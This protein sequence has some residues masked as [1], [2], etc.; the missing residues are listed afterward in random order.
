MSL[1]VF[2]ISGLNSSFSVFCVSC[3]MGAFFAFLVLNLLFNL[4]S[5]YL[6]DFGRIFAMVAIIRGWFRNLILEVLLALKILKSGLKFS[7]TSKKLSR[8]L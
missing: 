1:L 7:S 2:S 8:S 3:E 4:L 5:L 6:I